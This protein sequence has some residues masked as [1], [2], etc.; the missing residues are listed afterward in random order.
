M[1]AD[2][3]KCVPSSILP[4]EVLRCVK[5]GDECVLNSV[6]DSAYLSLWCPAVPGEAGLS[7]PPRR[8]SDPSHS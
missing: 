7:G 4:L 5:L 1:L 6:F 8:L 2:V 3:L